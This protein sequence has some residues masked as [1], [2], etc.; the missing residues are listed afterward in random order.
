MPPSVAES[1]PA[2]EEEMPQASSTAAVTTVR[3]DVSE[4]EAENG[5]KDEDIATPAGD[6]A[7]FSLNSLPIRKHSISRPVLTLY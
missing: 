3:L 5:A 7:Q 6:R 1:T 2:A 4:D